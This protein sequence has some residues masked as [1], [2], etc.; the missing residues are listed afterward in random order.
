MQALS[1]LSVALDSDKLRFYSSRQAL[2]EALNK[3]E[4]AVIADTNYSPLYQQR[5]RYFQAEIANDV[6]AGAWFVSRR[7][8]NENLVQVLRLRLSLLLESL[9]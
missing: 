4:V 1:D 7:L 9:V 6:S 8:T 3:G 2:V 5:E